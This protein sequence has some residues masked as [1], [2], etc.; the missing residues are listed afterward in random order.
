M[1]A[2][3][4]LAMVILSTPFRADMQ[5]VRLKNVQVAGHI[6]HKNCLGMP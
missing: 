2:I 4:R 3:K 6:L 1:A 5:A